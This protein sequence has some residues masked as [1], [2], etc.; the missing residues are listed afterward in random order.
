MRTSG[1]MESP[2]VLGYALGSGFFL[3]DAPLNIVLK[4]PVGS[5]SGKSTAKR[6]IVENRYQPNTQKTNM[7][8]PAAWSHMSE[9]TS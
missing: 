4:S 3:S 7:K 6:I 8:A 9:L 1:I 5:R 2:V